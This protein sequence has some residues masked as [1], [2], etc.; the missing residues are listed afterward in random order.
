MPTGGSVTH[1]GGMTGDSASN[2]A[3]GRI[4]LDLGSLRRRAE[5]RLRERKASERPPEADLKRLLYELEVHQ[6]ELEM[7]NEELR[8]ARIEMESALA[9]YTEMFEF[10]PIGYVTISLDGA[11]HELNHAAARLLGGTRSQLL[12]RRFDSF[13]LPSQRARFVELL[14][15][16][17]DSEARETSELELMVPGGQTVTVQLLSTLLA[18]AEPMILIAIQEVGV[19]GVA[20]APPTTE[21]GVV[22]AVSARSARHG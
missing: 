10:A 14:E 15:R 9:R 19:Q 6:I 18:R 5:E 4:T 1:A 13:V 12:Q 22:A 17:L 7:Q 11:L 2:M 3:K 16:V 8:E 21:S 20:H